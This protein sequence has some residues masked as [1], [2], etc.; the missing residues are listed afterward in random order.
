MNVTSG[1]TNMTS[2]GSWDTNVKNNVERRSGGA[3]SALQTANMTTGIPVSLL[4]VPYVALTCVILILMLVSFVHFHHRHGHKYRRRRTQLWGELNMPS[5]F[6]QF[7]NQAAAPAN[8]QPPNGGISI[9]AAAAPPSAHRAPPPGPP[10]HHRRPLTFL[11]N[12]N[13]SMVD[14]RCG[15]DAS[16]LTFECCRPQTRGSTPTL[17]ATRKLHGSAIRTGLFLTTGCHPSGGHDDEV[18]LLDQTRF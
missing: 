1:D 14:V 11:S 10:Q 4:W 9:S 6:R 17:W 2:V 15:I 8:S 3:T 13:G 18:Q 7:H 12:C 5:I 16:L